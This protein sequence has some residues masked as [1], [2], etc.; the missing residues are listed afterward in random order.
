MTDLI[1][2]YSFP[3]RYAQDI[4]IDHIVCDTKVDEDRVEEL[5]K[6]C[7]DFNDFKA[8]VL[9]LYMLVERSSKK[10]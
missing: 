5:R 6:D 8:M 9:P 3:E 7:D 10:T 4:P 2:A 1:R